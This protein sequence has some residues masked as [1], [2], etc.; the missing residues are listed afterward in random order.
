MTQGRESLLY[1]FQLALGCINEAVHSGV[2]LR[3]NWQ[4]NFTVYAASNDNH[5]IWDDFFE[6]PHRITHDAGDFRHPPRN[7]D[8]VPAYNEKEGVQHN[9]PL[10]R[11]RSW[12]SLGT[13][14]ATLST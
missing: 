3:I 7:V 11:E 4:D 8:L 12:P 1:L 2:A 6:Q 14:S 9:E 10:G 13:L 5:N